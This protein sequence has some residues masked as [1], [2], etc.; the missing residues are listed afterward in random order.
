MVYFGKSLP[1]AA[2]QT[3]PRA[4]S[5]TLQRAPDNNDN[6]NVKYVEK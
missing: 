4:F 3:C 1:Y 6:L 2:S 5:D